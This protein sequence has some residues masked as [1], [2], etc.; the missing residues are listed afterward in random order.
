MDTSVADEESKIFHVRELGFG[1]RTVRQQRSE[2]DL[3]HYGIE[4][5]AE[6]GLLRSN[7]ARVLL[8]HDYGL[9]I[10]TLNRL[11]AIGFG[12]EVIVQKGQ[13]RFFQSEP[14]VK[15]IGTYPDQFTTE[16][17]RGK[18][19]PDDVMLIVASD[20]AGIEAL[21]S[22]FP[23]SSRRIDRFAV[24]PGGHAYRCSALFRSNPDGRG[25]IRAGLALAKAFAYRVSSRLKRSV[26]YS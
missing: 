3:K 21:L 26:Q 14:D 17:K 23:G 10:A 25:V 2:K 16:N 11:R 6:I 9:A 12:A 4:A 13:E 7:P 20:V 8:S 5:L 22:L 1:H 18:S 19:L 15:V 24:L